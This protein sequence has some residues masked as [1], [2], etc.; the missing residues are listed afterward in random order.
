MQNRFVFHTA[1]EANQS[2]NRMY[3][4]S[5]ATI[6]TDKVAHEFFFLNCY[7]KNIILR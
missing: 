7:K 2:L 6:K 5:L 3:L 1:S 4:L